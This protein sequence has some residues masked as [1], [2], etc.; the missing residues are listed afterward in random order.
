MRKLVSILALLAGNALAQQEALQVSF[1]KVEDFADFGTVSWERERNQ[2]ELT[3]VLR[4]M[5]AKLPPGQQLAIKVLDVNRAGELEWWWRPGDRL[6]VMRNVSWPMIEMEF[7]L[8]QGGQ[9]LKAGK[10]RLADMSYLQSD[11]FSASQSRNEGW[12]YERRML[13]RWF[14]ETVLGK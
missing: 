5:A 3:E 2:T 8:T 14:K 11:H 9:T 1:A 10:V 7:S 6:R 13:D 4:E 12:R